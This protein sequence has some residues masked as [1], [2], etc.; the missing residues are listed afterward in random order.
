MGDRP[1]DDVDLDHRSTR[2]TRRLLHCVRHAF[3]LAV[4]DA[5]ASVLVADDDQAAEAE[6]PAT[7]DDGRAAI[8]AHH[9]FDEALPRAFVTAATAATAPL[10]TGAT[11]ATGATGASTARAATAACATWAATA[12][13]A[14]WAAT[15]TCAWTAT[16]CAWTAATAARAAA[17]TARSAATTG[18][19]T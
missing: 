15:A 12:A 8:D 17:T 6:A 9:G 2:L 16:A 18:T 5:H 14:T 1:V 3:G 7:L 13:C 11:L 19:T 4:A 10:T